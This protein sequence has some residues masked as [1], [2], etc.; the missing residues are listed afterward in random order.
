MLRSTI[1]FAEKYD[2]MVH[3]HLAESKSEYDFTMEQFGCSP[4]EWFR[5]NNL[6]G[7]RF[8]YDHCIHLDEQDIKVLAETGTGV[9]SC[10][11]SN[12]YL[13]SGSCQ[14]RNM[15]DA[16]VERIGLGV[17]GAA[18]SNSSNMMEEMRVAYLLNRLT[19]EENA[20]TS[21]NILYMATAGGAKALGR[22][23]I[24]TLVPGK[25]ADL[26]LLDWSS[27]SY[28]GGRNDPADCIVRSGDAR[29]V[30][31]VIVN[32]EIV[33]K[34]GRLLRIDEWQK[35]AYA[36]EISHELLQRASKHFLALQEEIISSVQ[37]STGGA[38]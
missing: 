23:D 9:V 7:D 4:V 37:E 36:D 20:C 35:S 32:G 24:G 17:D 38:L 25:A 3:G 8:Y 2:V 29:M 19:H 15:M 18:S 34:K 31:T 33:V 26:T 28:A 27:L 12:M 16:G 21:E 5:R 22:N 30:D 6:L 10:P 14:V 1:E 13:S 11:I